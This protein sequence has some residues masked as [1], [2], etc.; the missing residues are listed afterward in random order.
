MDTSAGEHPSTPSKL[1]ELKEEF[2]AKN[3]SKRTT[4]W[5]NL[6]L[7]VKAELDKHLKQQNP[8]VHS[9]STYRVKT[10][11]SLRGKVERL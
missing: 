3:F 9:T 6:A 2:I 4:F 11:E 7:F 1:E 5:E 8:V 10:E